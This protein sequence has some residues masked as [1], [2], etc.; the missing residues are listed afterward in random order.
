MSEY[1]K[2]FVG[3]E[4]KFP[5]YITLAGITYPDPTYHITRTASKEWVMEYI[6]EGEGYVVVNGATH[7]VCKDMIYIL[8][9]GEKHEYFSDR[10]KPFTKIF[11]NVRGNMCEE[12]ILA[13]G[14]FGKYFFREEGLKAF[15]EKIGGLIRSNI[16]DVEMQPILQGIFV[17]IIAKLS[18]SL[19]ETKYSDEAISL[20][21]YIDSNLGRIVSSEELSNVV[22]RSKDYC[23]KLFLREF[24]MTPYAYQLDRKIQTAKSLLLNTD[25]TVGEIAEKLGY[26]SVHY[27]SNLFERKCG[28]RP[29]WYRKSKNGRL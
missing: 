4:E 6:L 28:C 21:N 13:Y 24:N 19:M 29:T 11:M 12:I 10:E 20:R 17:E 27:F 5:F 23:Q 9:R 18:I 8:P 22:F 14:L 16:S 3:M 26:T 15:F 1:L 25:M 7:H 2:A